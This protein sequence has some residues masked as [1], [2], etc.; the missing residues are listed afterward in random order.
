VNGQP[1]WDEHQKTWFNVPQVAAIVDALNQAYA[2]G[3]KHFPDTVEFVRQY[4]AETVYQKHWLPL[5]KKLFPQ[6]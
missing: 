1:F 5:L 3:R 4:D 6:T 2:R